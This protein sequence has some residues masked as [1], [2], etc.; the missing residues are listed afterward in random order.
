MTKK[1]V[2]EERVYSAYIFHTAVNHQRMSG[3]E[4][5]NVRKKELMQWPWRD[6]PYWLA[7]PGLRSLLSY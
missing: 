4:L 1:P 2:V 5:K 3:L 7:S 6:F